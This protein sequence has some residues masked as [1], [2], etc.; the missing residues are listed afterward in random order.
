MIIFRDN[1]LLV[2]SRFVFT[3]ERCDN[4]ELPSMIFWEEVGMI[5]PV[6]VSM[7][8]YFFLYKVLS[9]EVLGLFK[10]GFICPLKTSWMLL[11]V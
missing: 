1:L 2:T 8:N 5:P 6:Y 3:K 4:F 11:T 7:S 9:R 10:S